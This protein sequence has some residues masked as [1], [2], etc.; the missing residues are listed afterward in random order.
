MPLTGRHWNS[1][2]RTRHLSRPGIH[3]ARPESL[4]VGLRQQQIPGP[5]PLKFRIPPVLSRDGP[6]KHHEADRCGIIPGGGTCADMPDCG[7]IREGFRSVGRHPPGSVACRLPRPA[8]RGGGGGGRDVGRDPCRRC[9]TSGAGRSRRVAVTAS[10]PRCLTTYV[11]FD[12]SVA[13][14]G[15]LPG[16]FVLGAGS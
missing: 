12:R 11:V 1:T 2:S 9:P 16:A 4:P 13:S 10:L 6:G 8:R 14:S 3:L 5:S 15:M 7:R